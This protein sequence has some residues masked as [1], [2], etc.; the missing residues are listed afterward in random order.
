[1]KKFKKVIALSLALAM[2]LSLAACTSGSGDT[3]APSGGDDTT[4]PSGNEDDTTAPSDN[5]AAG[6]E[7]VIYVWNNE[8]RDLMAD[9]MPGYTADED[10]MGGVMDDGTVIKFVENE[11]SGLNYQTKLTQA[12]MDGSQVDMFLVEA[13]YATKYTSAAAD[14]AMDIKDLGFTD[15]DLAQM[16]DYAKGV[17]TDGGVTRG[18]SWQC[19]PGFFLYRKDLA[20]EQLGVTSEAE[21]QEKIKDWDAFDATAKE[22]A[23]KG[24]YIVADY[25][26][27]SRAANA[28]R[29]TAWVTDGVITIPS[30]IDEWTERAK[31]WYD[32]GAMAGGANFD[33][34]GNYGLGVKKDGK[35]LGYFATTWEFGWPLDGMVDPVD[36]DTFKWSAVQGP[37]GYFWGGTWACASK[38]CSNTALAYDIMWNMT[39]NKDV[40]QAMAADRMNFANN[41]AAMEEIADSYQMAD[42]FAWFDYDGSYISMCLDLAENIEVKNMSPYDQMIENYQDAM[43]Q[44]FAGDSTKD[45]AL[46]TFYNSVTEKWT[47]LSAPN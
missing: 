7:F 5:N 10:H 28:Q 31:G 37:V 38:N 20:E 36:D 24:Y 41:K 25:Q 34:N 26:E 45:E 32:E 42:K 23:D 39:C 12:L 11:N 33:G 1:M 40:L 30:E 3:T 6:G 46:Q 4:A 27:G 35:V 15:D 47:E 22:L 18:V 8:F 29:S 13:D 14:V 9:Y 43:G 19:C 21:M 2:G 17:V 16:Y 44:Y